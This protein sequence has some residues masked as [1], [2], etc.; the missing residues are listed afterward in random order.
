MKSAALLW[1]E[2]KRRRLVRALIAWGI[3]TFAVLQVVEPVMHAAHWPDPVL[4]W[5]VGLLALGFPVVACIGWVLDAEGTAAG[6]RA[7][8][9]GL[10]LL[11]VALAL[12]AA[13]SLAGYGFF[14]RGG[15]AEGAAAPSIAVLPLTDM[16]SQHDQEYFGDGLSE[17]L[18][19]LLAKVPGL[20]V[21]GRTSSFAFKG[22][23]DDLRSIGQKL[24]VATILEGSVRK[25]GDRIRIT[26]QL[27]NAADGYHL[28]SETYDRKLTDVFAVQDEIAAAV[29]NA[30]RIKLLP[31]QA[32]S[33]VRTANPE[34]YNEFLLGKQFANQG[35]FE[36]FRRGVDAFQKAVALDARYAP[37]WA[38]LSLAEGRLGD[39]GASVEAV[40]TM[41]ERALASA[42][43]AVALDPALAEAWLARGVMRAI[44][45]RDWKGVGTDLERARALSPDSAETL[46]GVATWTLL[47][48]GRFE[49][50]IAILRR[51]CA[52]D[53][54][55]ADGWS[56]LGLALRDSGDL[57]A[58]R[59]PLARAVEIAPDS[60][61]PGMLYGS[62][63]L[64][65]GQPAEALA[66]F[67]RSGS[68]VARPF[69]TALAQHDL[70][71][72][73]ESAAA[74]ATLIEQYAAGWAYQVAD[75]YAWTGDRDRAFEWLER[76]YL[77]RD[78]GLLFLVR[79]D[80]LLRGLHDDP[81]FPAMLRK[82][83]LEP[84]P[85]SKPAGP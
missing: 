5:V 58:A 13:V 34:A 48:M 26:T 14:R 62:V 56:N 75:V 41:Q 36:G 53:P 47:P 77:H 78:P 55:N 15:Q 44:V 85:S 49:E 79:G 38:G 54:L 74:L 73:K 1:E 42:E 80:A 83:N 59:E 76:A 25:S 67:G 51:S 16:S 29:V 72:A 12:V 57:A 19:N 82:L 18:L 27:I 69:G 30:L 46:R 61:L 60:D 31:A 70:G 28:W 63:F 21:A 3:L 84:L 17:E 65:S 33:S 43:K 68:A 2:L 45:R 50:A 22:K 6:T 66:V 10:P 23:G 7:G 9:P 32:P 20:H 40:G 11:L 71:H 52:I 39:Y 64:L 35:S 4:S 81:R 8:K 37:A 24:N